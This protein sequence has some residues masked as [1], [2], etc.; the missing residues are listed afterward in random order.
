M[1]RKAILPVRRPV[2][3]IFG[4]SSVQKLYFSDD[5]PKGPGLRLKHLNR[6]QRFTFRAARRAPASGAGLDRPLASNTVMRM[7]TFTF[8]VSPEEAR[9]IRAKARAEKSSVSAFLRTR[10]LDAK[11]APRKVIIK[12]HPVSGL[13]YNATDVGGPIV[14][15]EQIKAALADFP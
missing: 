10:V 13:P 2:E 11:P 12:K 7:P 8:K 15:H 14:T 6:T 9:T 5:N 1:R 3:V 4:Q